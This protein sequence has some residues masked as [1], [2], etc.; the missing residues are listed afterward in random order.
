MLGWESVDRR[1]KSTGAVCNFTKYCACEVL[2]KT[3][4]TSHFDAFRAAVPMQKA[5][6]ANVKVSQK[7]PKTTPATKTTF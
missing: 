4:P 1:V 5:A 7:H 2:G 6:I 3:Q